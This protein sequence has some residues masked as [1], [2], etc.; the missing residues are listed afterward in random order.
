LWKNRES[1]SI[2]PQ[3]DVGSQQ[4]RIQPE[5][6]FNTDGRFPTFNLM[7]PYGGLANRSEAWLAPQPA[8]SGMS[9]PICTQHAANSHSSRE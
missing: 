2:R 5:S 6:S 3:F 9:L 4:W 1:F 8:G 7:Q